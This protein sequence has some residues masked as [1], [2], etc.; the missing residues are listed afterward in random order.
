MLEA[1]WLHLSS[2]VGLETAVAKTV[3]AVSNQ[4]DEDYTMVQ[5]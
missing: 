1:S 3:V 5:S 2:A 4:H